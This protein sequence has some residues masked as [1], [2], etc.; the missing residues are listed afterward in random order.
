MARQ[1]S[2]TTLSSE[3]VMG[4]RGPG[5]FL[6]RNATNKAPLA[7]ILLKLPVPET[8]QKRQLATKTP[9]SGINPRQTRSTQVI[10]SHAVLSVLIPSK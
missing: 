8:P 5:A 3:D 4:A 1:F 7:S 9:I 10:E 6:L 2:A